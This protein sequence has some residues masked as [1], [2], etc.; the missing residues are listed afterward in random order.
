MKPISLV[1]QDETRAPESSMN[2][3]VPIHHKGPPK[4]SGIHQWM[5]EVEPAGVKD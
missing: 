5:D 2:A 4:D 3:L 1:S